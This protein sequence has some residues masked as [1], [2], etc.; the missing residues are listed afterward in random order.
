LG[1]L[2]QTRNGVIS[3]HNQKLLKPSVCYG[4]ESDLHPKAIPDTNHNSRNQRFSQN[5]TSEDKWAKTKP[6]KKLQL[7]Q[8]KH[9][10]Q[11]TLW[12][13]MA[14]LPQN[15]QYKNTDVEFK[16]SVDLRLKLL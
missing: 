13:I 11:Q 5:P 10:I 8:T 9:M 7:P 2:K 1:F 14:T 6:N 16:T 4:L 15:D 12:M 3:D